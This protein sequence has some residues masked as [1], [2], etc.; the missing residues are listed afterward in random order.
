MA[1]TAISP[2][3]SLAGRSVAISLNQDWD[4]VARLVARCGATVTRFSS[5]PDGV[6]RS[7]DGWLST[8]QT[9]FDDLVV[10]SA[11][12]ITFL[13]ELAHQLNRSEQLMRALARLRRIAY[14]SRAAA[15]LSELGLPAMVVVEPASSDALRACLQASANNGRRVGVIPRSY[16]AEV[17]R[18][19]EER[20]EHMRVLWPPEESMCAV[21]AA[22]V[23]R[24]VAHAV[25]MILFNSAEQVQDLWA[26]AASTHSPE[27]FRAAMGGVRVVASGSATVR[28][29]TSLGLPVHASPQ[30]A[31]LLRPSAEKLSSLF[32]L[33][34]SNGM[35]GAS[36]PA[37]N[38]ATVNGSA[39]ALP[40]TTP[41][42]DEPRKPLDDKERSSNPTVVVIG[43]GMVGHKLVEKLTVDEHRGKYNIVVFGEE[44]RPAYDRVHLTSYF[45]DR[46]ASRLQLA[47]ARWYAERG[48]K[49]ILNCKAMRIDRDR[50]A[51]LSSN[52]EWTKYDRIVLCTGSVP[53]V[54]PIAG[55]DKKGVHV[56]RTIEDLEAIVS[57][58]AK[59]KRAVVLGGGLLGLEA[60]KAAADLGLETHVVEFA[61][62]LMPRQ[63]DPGGAR[64]LLRRIE[65]LGVKVHL[66]QSTQKILGEERVTG[67]T[68]SDGSELPADLVII[69]A[70]IRP[71]DELA[72]ECGLQVGD[73]GGVQVDDKLRT[74]DP[75][76][77]AVG[78]CALHREM[79]YGLVAPGYE[80]ADVA[81]HILLHEKSITG[82][83]FSGTDQSAKLKLLGVDVASLG[84]PFAD[85]PSAHGE[86]ARSI[87][88]EDLVRGV[89]KKLVV[90]PDCQHLLGAI[91][92][93]D[94][95][96]Y[97]QLL[98]LLR[99]QDKL[100]DAPEQLILGARDGAAPMLAMPD[101]AQVCS[102]NNVTRKEICGA[103]REGCTSV[104]EIKTCTKAGTG[105]GGCL[106]LV[107]DILNLELKAAGQTVKTDL[108]EH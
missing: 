50:R 65:E 52:G 62:R 95:A 43:N 60:A 79:V 46:D 92:V 57:D 99:S 83:E 85:T 106:P 72:R 31:D 96:E 98:H 89:Y 3:S 81:A 45:T 26:A 41:A 86:A 23:E 11:Q 37:L 28:A 94:A 107:T 24:I 90:S 68:F 33:S 78:E 80:M 8:V 51:V 2:L 88:Y 108:C 35:N 97:G 76:I 77:F 53:F 101:T 100:P 38:G 58:S 103:V 48:V 59:A 9:E 64:L 10:L 27:S 105:C 42:G 1:K 91:L 16:D 7:L 17:V 56:Y 19:I 21:S 54:P 13:A 74:S 36:K 104:A 34:A 30:G 82:K 71:R 6:E 69:S 66:N 102:C 67:I 32:G 5:G 20:S 25:D 87:V 75:D 39:A 61:P 18:L 47:D 4:A 63:L 70:G 44:P 55:T 29:L 14:G 15:A 22:I 12:G 49:L 73:R 93:G 40:T 84:N